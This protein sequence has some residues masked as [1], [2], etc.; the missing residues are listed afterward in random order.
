M[1][2]NIKKYKRS[3]F[4]LQFLGISGRGCCR[5]NCW[6]D[7]LHYVYRLNSLYN[8]PKEEKEEEAKSK[9]SSRL[10]RS[11]LGVFKR[12]SHTCK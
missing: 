10:L 4:V 6:D 9:K 12:L 1:F 8:Q 3:K 2:L 5:G 7:F 11:G